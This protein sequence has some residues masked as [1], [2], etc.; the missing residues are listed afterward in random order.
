MNAESP[1]FS[2]VGVDVHDLAL[3]AFVD[4]GARGLCMLQEGVEVGAV[5]VSHPVVGD[6]LAEGAAV[7]GG[8]RKPSYLPAHSLLST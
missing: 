2:D 4:A 3:A 8:V 5:G 7:V 1:V 6:P